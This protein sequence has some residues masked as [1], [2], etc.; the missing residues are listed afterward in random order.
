MTH[1]QLDTIDDIAVLRALVLEREAQIFS[2]DEQIFL[3]AKHIAA[4]DI[5]LD[6]KTAELDRKTAEIAYKTAKIESLTLEIARLRRLQFSA[7]SERFDPAQRALFDEAIEADI[8][9][10]EAQLDALQSPSPASASK[11]RASAPVRKPLPAHL[12]REEVVHAPA[13][14]T[15]EAC[16]NALVKI[17]EHVHE[18]LEVVPAKFFVRRDL[19]PQFA[20]RS[21]ETVV[22]EPVLPAIIDR[23]QAS[24]SLLAH[25][26]VSKYLDH[27]PLYRQE[28]IDARSGVEIGRS[29]RAEWIGKTGVA[30]KPLRDALTRELLRSAGLHADETPIQQLAPGQ[31]K[32]RRAYLF[33]YRSLGDPDHAPIIVFDYCQSRSG[34]HARAFLGDWRGALLVDDF[35][36]YKALFRNGI[37]ELGCWAHVRRKFFDLYAANK[38][39]V[40][41]E[42][43]QRIGA[44]YAVET[45][46]KALD[47]ATRAAYRHLHAKPLV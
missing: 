1:T 8:A 47:V 42:A 15:C 46:V 12:P 10:V 19:Y 7:K 31:G 38:S 13:T 33:A 3:Q 23:S 45:E 20:C 27:L 29:T 41:A 16:G 36:G 28:A 6:C 24:P 34:E 30:L 2:R 5:E 26:I 18:T 14:C 44:L 17:G 32:T 9:A 25:V 35:G 22:A 40:A 39:S 37:L 4:R 11:P 21:C 43:L